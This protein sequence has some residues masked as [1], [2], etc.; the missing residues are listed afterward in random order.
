MCSSLRLRLSPR[1][2]CYSH[3]RTLLRIPHQMRRLRRRSGQDGYLGS[4]M[5]RCSNSQFSVIRGC[6]ARSYHSTASV[7]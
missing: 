2:N 4:I 5:R 3:L 7:L 1:E 6:I